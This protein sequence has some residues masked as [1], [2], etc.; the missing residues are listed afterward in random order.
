MFINFSTDNYAIEIEIA[1]NKF[2]KHVTDYHNN[3]FKAMGSIP[4]EIHRC[5]VNP[6]QRSKYTFET[7]Y[8]FFPHI[9]SLSQHHIY[10]FGRCKFSRVR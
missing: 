4:R 1:R 2:T 10:F 5:E 3:I 7:I 8:S 6:P 9:F